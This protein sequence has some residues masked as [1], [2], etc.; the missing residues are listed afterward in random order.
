M[1]PTTKQDVLEFSVFVDIRDSLKAMERFQREM[2][3]SMRAVA[4]SSE[5]LGKTTVKTSEKSRKAIEDQEEAVEDLTEAYEKQDDT[6]SN[7]Q[8]TLDELAKLEKSSSGDQLAAIQKQRVELE[9]LLKVRQKKEKG[10]KNEKGPK[11]GLIFGESDPQKVT[12]MIKAELKEAGEALKAPLE[13]FLSKDAKG[14]VEHSFKLGSTVLQ[15][16]FK[17]LAGPGKAIAN[18]MMA[19]YTMGKA[20]GGLKGG[21]VGGLKGLGSVMKELGPALKGL[22][23]LGPILGMVGGAVLGLVKMFIDADS[24]AKEFNKSILQSASNLD[25][26]AR[27]GNNAELAAADME[28]TL[29]DLRSAAMDYT[30]NLRLGVTKDEHVAMINTLTQEGVSLG[31][32]RDEADASGKSVKDLAT[33]LTVTG[34]KYSRAFGVPIAEIGQL[35]AEMMTEMGRSLDET[36]ASFAMMTRAAADSGIASNKFFAA[37]RGV[38]QDLSLYNLRLED[39][40]ALLSKLGTVMSPRNA[41]KFMQTIMSMQSGL[42]RQQKLQMGFFVGQKKLSEVVNKDIARKTEN[43]MT[44]L[45]EST[46]MPVKALTDAFQKDGVKGIASALAKVPDEARGALVESL[47][48]LKLQ[49]SRAGKGF[50]GKSQSISDLGVGGFLDLLNTAVTKFAP[51]KNISEAVGS[52]GLE[53]TAEALGYSQEQ[54]DQMAKLQMAIETERQKLIDQAGDDTAK[55]AEI[56]KMSTQDII[57]GFSDHMKRSLGVDKDGLSVDERIE[58]LAEKQGGLTQ[59]LTDKLS[60][61]VDW[62]MNTF[63]DTILGLWADVADI[64]AKFGVGK[65]GGHIR[66]MRAARD[67]GNPELTNIALGDDVGKGLAESQVM[68]DVLD[69]LRNQDK[70]MSD[71]S[72]QR[73]AVQAEL[74]QLD[75]ALSRSDDPALQKQRE[76]RAT[77]LKGLDE[78][79]TTQ[80][81]DL[82][83]VLDHIAEK[84]SAGELAD[85]LKM[86]GVQG[87]DTMHRGGARDRFTKGLSR[88][89]DFRLA[90]KQAGASQEQM[91]EAIGK[92]AWSKAEGGTKLEAFGGAYNTLKKLGL[93]SKAPATTTPMGAPAAKPEAMKAL[94]G[95]TPVKPTTVAKAKTD[96]GT[97]ITAGNDDVVGAVSGLQNT[98]EASEAS[99]L[100]ALQDIQ[101]GN[102]EM[103]K[104][105]NQNYRF[106]KTQYI[107]D[108]EQAVLSAARQALFEYYLYSGIEDRGMV[109]EAFT[110]AGGAAQGAKK[111]GETLFQDADLGAEG[112]LAALS[113]NADGGMVTGVAGGLAQVRAAAGEGLASIGPG[114]RILPAGAGTSP[115]VQI[116]VNGVGGRDLANLIEGKVVEGIREFKRREKYY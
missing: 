34:V 44:K 60:V 90:A 110:G 71:I 82:R 75:E 41:Q 70:H 83:T 52:I 94:V 104:T 50:Y 19:G 113:G 30:T 77:Q 81:E 84:F 85:A 57:D 95:A 17:G 87:F 26:L 24:M 108:T 100:S 78:T 36:Q 88:T 63:Y 29:R 42:G 27:S 64:A 98:A 72:K 20:E 21:L 45:S 112:A 101:S 1:A 99:T 32:I 7:L 3:E 107:K 103:G 73:D 74:A 40:V 65:G 86:A 35:Q 69:A 68:K 31:R 37:I 10:G 62:F 111:L 79:L 9:R 16:T 14:L 58:K 66:A 4:K 102:T 67:A 105:L 28:D 93:T 18:R 38:S 114:E 11:G 53:Q 43:L 13:A 12:D 51:N 56:N 97:T 22:T 5:D 76:D 49:Q 59:T 89:K 48:N 33:Q 106:F 25:F 54:V 23:Q 80:Q 55:I 115:N 92:L 116:S 61:L 109:A 47:T 6:V 2:A 15:K 91:V 39:S 8:Q 96:L 46:Q